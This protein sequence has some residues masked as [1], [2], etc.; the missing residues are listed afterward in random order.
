MSSVED[1]ILVSVFCSNILPEPAMSQQIVDRK[2]RANIDEEQRFFN[3][4]LSRKSRASRNAT[5]GVVLVSRV[6]EQR[7]GEQIA[8]PSKLWRT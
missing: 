1:R 5:L 8:K 2:N 4:F 3:C 6:G 7:S